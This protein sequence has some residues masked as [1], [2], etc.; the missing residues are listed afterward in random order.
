MWFVNL[1]IDFGALVLAGYMSLTGGVANWIESTFVPADEIEQHEVAI[2]TEKQSVPNVLLE[3]AGFQQAAVIASKQNE[4]VSSDVTNVPIQTLVREALVNVY[5][6]YKTPEYIRT[7]TGSGYF[8]HEKGVIITNAHVAQFLLLEERDNEN[9]EVDCIIRNGDPATQ[10]YEA[11]LLYISPT[12]VF[13]NADLIS[14]E[15]PRGTGERDYA[16][17]Y[18]SKSLDNSPLPTRFPSIPIDTALL[19]R[20]IVGASVATAGYPAE[21]LFKYGADAKLPLVFA[22]STIGILYTFGSNFADIFSITDSVVGEH[23]ASGGPIV[24][25]DTKHAMGLIV[26]KGDEVSE[27]PKS[28]RALTLSYID[29]TMV[30]ETGYS[31]AQNMQ[32][33]VAFRGNIFKNV[34]TPFLAEI[35]EEEIE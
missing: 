9:V 16:L 35:L 12:W 14:D 7:T 27:G 21:E 2:S 31:L 17:L 29:R 28:L 8:I 26:T 1:C 19:P 32:G 6:Q 30:E 10:K 33:D 34:M 13:E 22:S 15:R 25:A 20:A 24:R 18:I 5:C 3:S 4:L 11:E 23:G